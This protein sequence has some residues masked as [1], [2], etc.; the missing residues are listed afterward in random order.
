LFFLFLD[1][2][3]AGAVASQSQSKHKT[4]TNLPR[5]RLLILPLSTIQKRLC[6]AITSEL[7]SYSSECP[8]KITLSGFFD[9]AV[10][11]GCKDVG[12]S[13]CDIS[14]GAKGSIF[15][16]LGDGVNF[17]G[18]TTCDVGAGEVA[19]DLG[20]NMALDGVT[21]N[22]CEIDLTM[23]LP[24]GVT[25]PDCDCTLG[26]GGSDAPLSVAVE[27]TAIVPPLPPTNTPIVVVLL[28]VPCGNVLNLFSAVVNEF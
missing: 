14:L 22:Q 19:L 20:G 12:A 16:S 25:P 11:V 6:D 8:C 23:P 18:K 1:N 3:T 17:D 28:N 2:T 26:C 9:F 4:I 7:G 5:S 13:T 21:L 15:G 10:N 24:P 27:C